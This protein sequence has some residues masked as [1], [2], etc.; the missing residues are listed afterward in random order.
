MTLDDY[1]TAASA[2]VQGTWNLHQSTL[3]HKSPISFFTLLSSMSGIIGQKAQA[4]YSA[5]NVFMDAFANYRHSQGLPAHS[6]D[7]GIIEEVGFAAREGG[8]QE[9]MD[10]KIWLG[11][12]E[13]MVRRMFKYSILQQMQQPINPDSATQLIIGI[14]L[15]QRP[16]SD[17]ESDARFSALFMNDSSGEQHKNGEAGDENAKAVQAFLLLH[18][19]KA[20]KGSLVV[21]G[22][23]V[24]NRQFMKTLRLTEAMEP[25]RSLSAYGVDSLSA[26]E[27]RNWV[28]VEL[29][30]ELTTLDITNASSLFGLCER[31][32]SKMPVVE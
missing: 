3:A 32:I 10:D 31:L 27:V 19:S 5:A 4:N 1:Y 12:N 15:P 18:R 13:S 17:L 29:G 22:V 21:A 24:L 25:A 7:L 11:V 2:K 20:D 6:L 28:R 9:R 23:E 16:G 26:V 8:I 14:S 30:V